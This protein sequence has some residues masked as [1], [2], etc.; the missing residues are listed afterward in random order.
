MRAQL[1]AVA[2]L[3]VVS[4]VVVGCGGSKT[5]SST[6]NSSNATSTNTASQTST[7]K[8]ASNDTPVTE[9]M[10]A[11]ADLICAKLSTELDR[12]HISS[13]ADIARVIPHRVAL[14]TV[15]LN[16]LSK[17]TPPSS[18]ASD[19]GS[20]LATRS[21]LIAQLREIN[22]AVAAKNKKTVQSVLAASTIIARRMA[23]TA[24]HDGFHHCGEL[25]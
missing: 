2:F 11:K 4:L 5:G 17:L 7:T 18:I 12:D 10:I 23:A 1:S 15:A 20:M 22:A 19:Y 25:G 8:P 21:K 14:E 24:Q 9:H 16:S 6:T 13:E 3:V